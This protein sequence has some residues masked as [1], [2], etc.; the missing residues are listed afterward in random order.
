MISGEDDTTSNGE[1][2]ETLEAAKPQEASKA[3]KPKEAS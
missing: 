1:S 3:E 2:L